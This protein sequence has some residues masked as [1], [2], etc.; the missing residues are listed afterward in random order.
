LTA[1]YDGYLIAS[2]RLRNYCVSRAEPG[3]L[4]VPLP[5]DDEFFWL[6]SDRT[7]G[8]DAELRRTRFEGRCHA[9]G[10]F[11]SVAGAY[12]VMLCGVAEPLLDGFYRTDVEFGS[13]PQQEPLVIVGVRTAQALKAEKF[14]GLEL[15]EVTATSI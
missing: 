5:A 4:F 14:R 10:A 15:G 11:C 7:I 9:C 13:G 12:P 6:R 8:F 3:V 1:T 2:R